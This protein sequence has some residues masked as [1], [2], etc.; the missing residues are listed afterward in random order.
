MAHT[1]LF[2]HGLS[3]LENACDAG[4]ASAAAGLPAQKVPG[5]PNSAPAGMRAGAGSAWPGL[6]PT[7]CMQAAAA[8]RGVARCLT[9]ATVH[10]FTRAIVDA[11]SLQIHPG[12]FV[13]FN[14]ASF[15]SDL[16]AGGLQ[17]GH[18]GNLHGSGTELH[19]LGDQQS[20]RPAVWHCSGLLSAALPHPL[21]LPT[22]TFFPNLSLTH[23][24]ASR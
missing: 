20:R 21:A 6:A 4:Q 7:F 10:C 12:Q 24:T 15:L 18:E 11:C 23:L 1:V 2:F 22:S 19:S 17:V 3:G 13:L 5:C 9:G 14:G 8:A 16:S